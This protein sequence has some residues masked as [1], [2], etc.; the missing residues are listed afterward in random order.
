MEPSF[1][2]G[3]ILTRGERDKSKEKKTH[4]TFLPFASPVRYCMN[5]LLLL[6]W[7]FL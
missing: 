2:G 6:G 5:E 1:A 3:L 4:E 7:E